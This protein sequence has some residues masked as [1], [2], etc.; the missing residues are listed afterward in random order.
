MVGV[1]YLFSDHS[2]SKS[3]A[4]AEAE[5]EYVNVMGTVADPL[6]NLSDTS[7]EMSSLNGDMSEQPVVIPPFYTS[8]EDRTYYYLSEI[9]E[10]DRKRGVRYSKALGIRYLGKN[11]NG[12]DVLQWSGGGAQYYCRRPCKVI[13][14]ENGER[15][16]AN[17][18]TII[19]LAFADLG[20]GYLKP[21]QV[22]E[23]TRNSG[24]NKSDAP[25]DFEA[26]APPAEPLKD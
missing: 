23:A 21:S 10:A 25:L 3:S 16:E 9:P 18:Q 2:S 14:L 17:D 12:E 24:A 11:E 8:V 15:I 4:T 22:P 5:E 20:R 7:E 6:E 26:P 1:A 13:R 19:G